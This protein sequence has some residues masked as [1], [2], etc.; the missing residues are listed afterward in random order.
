MNIMKILH[1]KPSLLMLLIAT[2]V[3]SGCGDSNTSTTDDQ[4]T[5]TVRGRENPP[6]LGAQIDRIGRPAISTATVGTFA[7]DGAP[8]NDLK[9]N[10]NA[11]EDPSTWAGMYAAGIADM[12]AIYDGAD[13]M[14][15]NQ[16]GYDA[17]NGVAGAY[18]FLASVLADDRLVIDSSTGNCPEYLGYEAEVLEVVP[19]GGC[20]GRTPNHDVV[21]RSYSVLINGSLG[22]L[23]DAVAA[24]A[25]THSITT[26]PF[27][28][29][30]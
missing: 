24:D 3:A 25:E 22:D 5:D 1:F 18:D 12:I 13:T 11:N 4:G 15:G 14:C 6:T 9:D 27:L 20:G 16:L 30:P 2:A 21:D 23:G 17:T 29:A 7:P 26:F 8:R 10:Y 28:A 19:E